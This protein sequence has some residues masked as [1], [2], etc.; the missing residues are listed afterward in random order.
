[1]TSAHREVERKVRVPEDFALADLTSIT[2]VAST[3]QYPPVRMRATYFDTDDLRLL[4]W[5]V[6]MR[7]REGGADEGWHLKLPVAGAEAGTRDELHVDLDATDAKDSTTVPDAF[8]HVISPLLRGETAGP[9]AV[10]E[11]TRTRHD[12]VDSEGVTRAELVDDRVAIYRDGHRIG[13]FHEIEIEACD[14]G[15][16]VALSILDSAVESLVAQGGTPSTVSKAAGALGPSAALPCDIPSLPMPDR[17]ALVV[18]ALRAILA[19][20]ARHLVMADVAVRRDLPDAVHQMRVAAR[21]LR[22]TLAAFAPVLD[23]ERA[24]SLREEL[25]WL[26]SELGAVRDTEVLQARLDRHARELP[27]PH[28]AAAASAVDD[29]LDRRMAAA[30]SSAIAALR[31]DRHDQL[32]DDLV[33]AVADPP[34]LDSAFRRCDELLHEIAAQTWRKLYRDARKLTLDSPSEQW[35][36]TRIRA[37]RARYTNEA[38]ASILGGKFTRLAA[39]LAQVTESLGDHQDAHIAQQLLATAAAGVD[40]SHGFALGLLHEYEGEE[41]ILERLRFPDIW[42]RAVKAARKAGLG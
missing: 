38:V 22:S 16:P 19:K 41:E 8:I 20:H 37:K 28:A 42:A 26:A 33:A 13:S 21:R 9:R 35:H 34:V 14:A 36:R 30:R 1:M 40:G 3:E 39:E 17:T 18:D 4:R 2:G 25:A 11:T 27:E 24:S 29:V 5:G 7:R 31:S 32:I 12:L 23:A 10:V 15:D 6:T